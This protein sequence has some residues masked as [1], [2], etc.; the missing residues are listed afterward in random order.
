MHSLNISNFSSRQVV[1]AVERHANLS[2]SQQ[3]IH[4]LPELEIYPQDSL[5]R[6]IFLHI[7]KTAGTNVDN[8]AKAFS[9]MTDAFH[10]LRLVVPRIPGSS[11]IQITE[12]WLGGCQQLTLHPR[13]LDSIPNLV[14]LQDIFLMACISI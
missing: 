4:V 11:P 1:G 12:G 3:V 13:L 8:I 10:Y 7:P 14:F 9:I 5:K 6:V 2:Y